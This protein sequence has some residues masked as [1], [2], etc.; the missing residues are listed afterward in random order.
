MAENSQKESNASVDRESFVFYRSF[1]EAAA[2]L[3]PQEKAAVFTAICEYAL[4][5]REPQLEGAPMAIFILIKPQLQ[6]NQRRYE[7]G[8]KGGRGRSKP[9]LKPDQ[10]ET[11]AKPK[12]NQT[13]TKDE[14][15]E[16]ANANVNVNANENANANGNEH[17]NGN[18]NGLAAPPLSESRQELFRYV[19]KLRPGV[20]GN[21]EL[22]E[23]LDR[24][25]TEGLV[26]WAADKAA[27]KG[28]LWNYARGILTSCL[29]SGQKDILPE[30]PAQIGWGGTD[31]W[32]PSYDIEKLER[33]GLMVPSIEELERGRF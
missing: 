23:I 30:P 20:A 1:Y 3:K 2:Q 33:R 24:G 26:R 14:P 17:S 4:N 8:K 9:E 5:G 6:A 28:K 11:E 29:D 7:A 32:E 19:Q 15:N 21:A 31:S 13:E 10:M 25:A 12:A 16:N 27:S 22:R 18:V